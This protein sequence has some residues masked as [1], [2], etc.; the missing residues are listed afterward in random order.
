MSGWHAW[1]ER[2]ADA[3]RRV[4]LHGQLQAGAGAGAGARLSDPG[5]VWSLLWYFAALLASAV[6]MGQVASPLGRVLLALLP[7]P[8]LLLIVGLSVRRVLGMDEL[9][10]RIELVALAIVAAITWLGF[11]VGWM[12]R[13]AGVSGATPLLGF[14]GMPLLY[15]FARRWAS[16]RYA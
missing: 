1:Q 10:R 11:G 6:S 15:L 5:L 4:A 16:R 2:A 9:Q 3:L 14:W 12:L 8:P 7:L 13:H